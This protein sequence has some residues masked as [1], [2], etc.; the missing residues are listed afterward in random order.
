M[1]LGYLIPATLKDELPKAARALGETQAN[2]HLPAT[3]SILTMLAFCRN[4]GQEHRR[5]APSLSCL[6]E[7][8]FAGEPHAKVMDRSNWSRCRAR[9]RVAGGR[10]R[11][12]QDRTDPAVFRPVR[13]HGEPDG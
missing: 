8:E 7:R 5:R 6:L 13:R 9:H 11:A 12:G 3:G 2:T 1:R 10:P 4:N